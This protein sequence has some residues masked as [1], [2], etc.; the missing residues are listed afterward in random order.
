[1]LI[2]RFTLSAL[3]ALCCAGTLEAQQ[4]QPA[5]HT[6]AFIARL[7]IDTISVERFSLADGA[8]NVEQVIHTPVA[9]LYH[10][11]LGLTPQGTIGDV[12]HM[13]HDIA[14]PVSA[15]L[16]ASTRLTFKGD[17]AQVLRKRGDSSETRTIAADATLVPSLPGAWLPYEIAA[18]RLRASGADSATMHFL[19]VSGGTQRVVARRVGPDSMT[20]AL[21]FLTYRASVDGEGRILGLYQPNGIRVERVPAIDINGIAARWDSL[22]RQGRGMGPL[23]PRDSTSIRLGSA[24][25]SVAYGRPG[26]RGR[27]IWGGLVPWDRVWR[28]GANDPTKLTTTHELQI[29]STVVPPGSYTLT[30]LPSPQGTTL[31]ISTGG[32]GGREVGRVDLE[33]TELTTP[34]E[35]FT[36]ELLPAQGNRGTLALSWDRRRMTAPIV[37]R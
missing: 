23:S 32:N 31:I 30:T 27:N 25:V 10:T 4:N 6:G 20:F 12:I 11:H 14:S 16:L 19:D 18:R 1:M 15:P 24:D 28:T 29:G 26:M 9:A 35:K 7:G 34:V 37:V 17:S 13:H 5:A 2:S 21:P 22:E 8:Y 36:I 3:A 33:T